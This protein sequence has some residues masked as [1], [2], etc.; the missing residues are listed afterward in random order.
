[1]KEEVPAQLLSDVTVF[2][3]LWS[4]RRVGS[5]LLELEWRSGDQRAKMGSTQSEH[6]EGVSYCGEEP[7]S[8][9]LPLVMTAPLGCR[10]GNCTGSP[11]EAEGI[12]P[13]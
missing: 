13:S 11:R 1:M 4:E 8:P 2:E 12:S 7:L 10:R 5:A 6:L 3:A 9:S